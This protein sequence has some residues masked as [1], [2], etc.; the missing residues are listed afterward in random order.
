M[1]VELFI[2]KQKEKKT[3]P[4]VNLYSMSELIVQL[5]YLV[6]KC[7]H[8]RDIVL[9]LSKNMHVKKNNTVYLQYSVR[10]LKEEEK[11]RENEKALNRKQYAEKE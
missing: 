1:T 5:I 6:F 2:E 9:K 8:T 4:I 7:Y 11:I 3:L 10:P